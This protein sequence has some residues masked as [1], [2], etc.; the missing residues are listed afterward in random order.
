[1]T[2]IV[3]RIAVVLAA[4][5]PLA[6]TATWAGQIDAGKAEALALFTQAFEQVRG[7]FVEDADSD[8]LI[9]AALNGMLTALDPHSKYL[10]PERYADLKSQ[11]DGEYGGIGVEMTV[12]NG[13]IKV[14]EPI[15]DSPAFRA[16]VL[17]GDL[18]THINGEPVAV[19]TLTQ[20]IDRMRG[21][22]GTE[23]RLRVERSK[24]DQS[25]ELTLMREMVKSPA[26][27]WRTEGDIGYVRIT[28]FSRQ[29]QP[30]L[31]K[32]MAELDARQGS[33]LLGYVLDLRDNPGGLLR[34]S[35]SVADS[36]LND[37]DIVSTRGRTIDGVRR[38]SATA[39]D[40]AHG[41]PM[42]VLVN[43]RTASASEIVAGALQ[44]HHRAILLGTRTF[45]KGSVQTITPL[46]NRGAVRM[47]TA[48]YYTPSGRS[49]QA[50]GIEPDIE[51]KPAR[52]TG[53]DGKPVEAEA[54]YQLARAL[55]L[56]RGM[57]LLHPPA[58]SVPGTA[59]A[60]EAAGAPS[61]TA[62]P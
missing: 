51:V 12:E 23:I 17:A 2:R 21:E 4:L 56:L 40:L 30:G 35:V 1:M 33:R 58:L 49:I 52:L 53:T 61:T 32:A 54:D 34:Q 43:G 25:F 3:S 42:V 50:L 55:D 60:A 11:N 57:V 20:A 39:G 14:L 37:G 62:I 7:S 47:T 26:V 22:I 18:F 24:A 16:G 46:A 5:L 6:P 48:R 29:T 41:R 28:S 36:F 9:E 38:F 19:T 44:D 31:E 27:R 45:G 13:R 8:K 10:N 59:T 15:E